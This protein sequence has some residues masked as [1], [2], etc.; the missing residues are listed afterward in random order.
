MSSQSDGPIY[1][2]MIIEQIIIRSCSIV[3]SKI[4]VLR[5]SCFWK[6]PISQKPNC[7]TLRL[8]E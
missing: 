4:H 5:Y 3:K 7:K 8:L 6:G 1:P 2:K